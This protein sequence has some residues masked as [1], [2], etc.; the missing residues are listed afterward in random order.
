MRRSLICV[1]IAGTAMGTTAASAQDA[2]GDGSGLDNSLR[3]GQDRRN[4]SRPGNRWAQTGYALGDGHALDTNLRIGSGGRNTDP[5]SFRAEQRFRDA[6]VTG[7][8]PGGMSFRGDIGYGAVGDISRDVELGSDDLFGFRRDSLYS[9][10]AGRGIRGTEALQYQF[11][12]ATG[13]PAPGNFSGSLAMSRS[14]PG[15]GTWGVETQP[16]NAPGAA[17]EDGIRR[18]DQRDTFTPYESIDM[19]QSMR[20]PSSYIANQNL[21]PLVLHER[22]DRMGIRQAV[23]GS[24]LGGIQVVPLGM[25]EETTSTAPGPELQVDTSAPTGA[26]ERDNDRLRNSYATVVERLQAMQPQTQEPADDAEENPPAVPTWQQNLEELQQW[27]DEQYGEEATVPP[28]MPNQEFVNTLREGGSVSNLAPEA[29]EGVDFY[30]THMNEAQKLL[31]EGRFFDAEQRFTRAMSIQRNDP[32]AQIGRVHAQIGAGMFLS[33][34]T[35]L[36]TFAKAHPEMVGVRYESVLRPTP[37]RERQLI[38]ML[39]ENVDARRGPPREAALL[40][41]YVGYQHGDQEAVRNGIDALE[42]FDKAGIGTDAPSD[43]ASPVT[44]LLRSV[45]VR[46]TSNEGDDL[47]P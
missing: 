29:G 11:S 21:Q 28:P 40:L 37:E 47:S 6:I 12:L 32:L 4:V 39:Q 34:A 13:N 3:A 8:A 45:W 14:S 43:E 2:L 25:V 35:N 15:L 41:A 46:P 22:V 27:L 9:G 17:V 7:N 18:T 38:N 42:L 44:K 23:T 19:L 1:L 16:D 36:R 31:S 10:L 20:S 30:V 24:A 5:R 26:A 33:A